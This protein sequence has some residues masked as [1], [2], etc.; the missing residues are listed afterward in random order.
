VA[1]HRLS[2]VR[3]R[4]GRQDDAVD[5]RR[6]GL[7]CLI[8]ALCAWSA[9]APVSA[10]VAE[11]GSRNVTLVGQVV[12]P[13]QQ[14]VGAISIA[15][16][17][18]RPFAYVNT[19][20]SA[21]GIVALDVSDAQHPTIIGRTAVT[22]AGME[23]LNVGERADGS[24]FLLMTSSTTGGSNWDT[25]AVVEV[26]DPTAPTQ[27]AVFHTE[28]PASTGSH[29]WTCVN[30]ECTYAYST[31]APE[32][33]TV[34][35]L[36]DFRRPRLTDP[37]TF[38][39]LAGGGHD[40]NRDSA[41]VMWLVGFGG[42][43]AYD[44]TDPARPVPLNTSDLNG[45]GS[46]YNDPGHHLHNTMRPNA[47]RFRTDSGPAA[48]SVHDGNVLLVAEEGDLV[49]CTDS[50][51]TWYVP[52]LD[53]DRFRAGNPL[54][55]PNRGTVTPIDA[56]SLL[57]DTTP[58]RDRPLVAQVCSVH[59]FDFHPRG[60]V[61]MAAYSSGTRVLDVRDPHAI[62]EVGYHF[63]PDDGAVQ[64]YWVPARDGTGRTTGE[65]TTLVY[66]TDAG[67]PGTVGGGIAVGGSVKIF[68]VKLPK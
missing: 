44:A 38:V 51:Q 2:V 41:G 6:I 60:F 29:T 68:Q 23:D 34:V 5:K 12:D 59:F 17:T 28:L 48:A 56:W 57:E 32:P 43:A 35:D 62:T 14:L 58:G 31:G 18:R 46:L 26:T 27:V 9:V 24:A 64:A 36:T 1:A 45:A 66:T 11:S 10:S 50:F 61:V 20:G 65:L 7:A 52:H 8:S 16:E 39:S 47:Q 40:W 67:P 33:I 49:D 3:Q 30:P 21:S 63:G 4:R 25:L 37:A 19:R 42:L 53:A 54:L 13:G 15:F 55:L 22:S